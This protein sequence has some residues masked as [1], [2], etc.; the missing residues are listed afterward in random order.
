MH[1]DSSCCCAT[2]VVYGVS[3]RGTVR[4]RRGHQAWPQ[5]QPTEDSTHRQPRQGVLSALHCLKVRRKFEPVLVLVLHRTLCLSVLLLHPPS[6]PRSSPITFG[7]AGEMEWVLRN[8][9]G[10]F[11]SNNPPQCG[12]CGSF[13][14]TQRGEV[15]P[16]T[17]ICPSCCSLPAYVPALVSCPLHCCASAKLLCLTTQG[18]RPC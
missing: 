15:R 4:S 1:R 18:V 2:A 3:S 11:V 6:P 8:T 14:S 5:R 10:S 12:R 16:S 9:I 7:F 13:D 17:G